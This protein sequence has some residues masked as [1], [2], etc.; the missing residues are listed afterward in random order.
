MQRS[1]II[2]AI[3]LERYRQNILHPWNRY[4][5]RLAVLVEELGEVG[6]ALQDDDTDNLKEELIQLAA[7]CVR[8]LEEL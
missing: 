1:D 8:W 4:T 6:T 7:L 5:P 2:E 3:F